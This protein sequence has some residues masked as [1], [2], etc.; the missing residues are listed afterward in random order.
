MDTPTTTTVPQHVSCW[1]LVR[2]STSISTADD[3]SCIGNTVDTR[4]NVGHVRWHVR[5]SSLVADAVLD[6]GRVVAAGGAHPSAPPR[7]MACAESRQYGSTARCLGRLG[8]AVDGK[9]YYGQGRLREHAR[10]HF[11]RC[12]GGVSRDGRD[13]SRV[14]CWARWTR[15]VATYQDSEARQEGHVWRRIL[16]DLRVLPEDDYV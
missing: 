6:V 14:Q 12:D 15:Y 3:S 8:A 9:A 4:P 10:G 11:V 5:G 13:C 2:A 16:G 7:A 1:V